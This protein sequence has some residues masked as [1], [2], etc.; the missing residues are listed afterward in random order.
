MESAFLPSSSLSLTP[1]HKRASP[2]T[3][4]QQMGPQ[5][6]ARRWL[7]PPSPRIPQR[8]ARA[9]PPPSLRAANMSTFFQKKSASLSAGPH[10]REKEEPGRDH[11]QR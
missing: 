1:T 7:L 3:S 9:Y 11:G 8:S 6:I 5:D 10:H 4:S 2:L